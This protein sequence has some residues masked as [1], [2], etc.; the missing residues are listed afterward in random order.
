M[1]GKRII[2]RMF[3]FSKRWRPALL[4]AFVASMV[5]L[6]PPLILL[7]NPLRIVVVATLGVLAVVFCVATI[8]A[9]YYDLKDAQKRD[10]PPPPTIGWMGRYYAKSEVYISHKTRYQP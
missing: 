5:G 9:L 4:T 6:V 3:Q 7:S 10:N 1:N 8:I 2:R